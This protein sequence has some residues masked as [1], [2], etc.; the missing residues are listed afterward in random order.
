[1][2]YGKKNQWIDVAHRKSPDAS[3]FIFVGATRSGSKPEYWDS[4]EDKIDDLTAK[5]VDFPDSEKIKYTY[6]ELELENRIVDLIRHFRALINCLSAQGYHLSCNLTAGI[7]EQRMALYL[8]SEIES[9]KVNE[10][11]YINKQDFNKNI[12]FK[13][14]D[15]TGKGKELLEIIFN[16]IQE[17]KQNTK[18]FSFF[19][20]A[21]N[22]TELKKICLDN[23]F[24][25]DLPALSRLVSKLVEQDYLKEQREGRKKLIGLTEKGL[26]FCPV[27][28]IVPVLQSEIQESTKS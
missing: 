4:I 7:F 16:Y 17:K 28:N 22:L 5:Q 24:K 12:L 6:L 8:A 10:V 13:T 25:T 9:E 14:I 3:W 23:G 20:Y 2:T 27:G 1:M 15:I 19:N 11:F 26:I 21:F 18:G